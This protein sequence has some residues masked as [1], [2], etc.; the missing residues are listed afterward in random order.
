MD[1]GWRRGGERVEE[2]WGSG[3]LEGEEG[4]RRD[5]VVGWMRSNVEV[6]EG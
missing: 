5:Q 6:D 2:E 3:Q 1:E 4:W